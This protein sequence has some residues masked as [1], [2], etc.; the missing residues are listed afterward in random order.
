M[1]RVADPAA[2]EADGFCVLPAVLSPQECDGLALLAAGA[3]GSAN[4]APGTRSLLAHAWCVELATRLHAHSMI[5]ALIPA[6]HQAVQC[7]YFEKSVERNWLVPVH[8]DLAIPVAERVDD[9]ALRGWS[10]KEGSLFVQPP[11]DVLARLVAVRV[12][13]DRCSA[14]DGPLQFVPGSHRQG[15]IGASQ[16]AAMRRAGTLA[17]PLL[18]RGDLLAMRPL[19]LHASSKATGAG[20]RRVLHFVF[21]PP[22]LPFGLRWETVAS[23]SP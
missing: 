6:S 15:R 11:A 7:T 16:A 22:A 10:R 3:A 13:L 4:D 21:G 12:H 23:A 20:R 14:E 8:Q 19:A 18:E 1:T 2:F 17:A 5:A 9:P